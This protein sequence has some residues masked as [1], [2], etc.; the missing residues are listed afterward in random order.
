MYL[1]EQLLLTLQKEL[2][3][4]RTH[5]LLYYD[6]TV[7]CNDMINMYIGMLENQADYNIANTFNNAS[8]HVLSST[9]MAS[10]LA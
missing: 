1:I 5:E 6:V 8:S 3:F 7:H 9:I 2:H 4:T 10:E